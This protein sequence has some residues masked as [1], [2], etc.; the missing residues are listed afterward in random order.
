MNTNTQL[1]HVVIIGA[2]F[3][4]LKAARALAHAPVQVTLIDRNNYHLFQP[5]LYQVATAGITP[6][7]IAYPVRSIFR[8]QRNLQFRLA[9]VKAIDVANRQLLTSRGVVPY[10]SLIVAAGGE[11][12][13]FGLADVAR[14]STGMKTLEDATA[15]RNHL[16]R[17]FE[18]AAQEED[19][20]QR[21]AHLSFVIV[22]GGPTGVETAGALSE[23]VEMILAHD[24]PGV[25]REEISVILL[26]ANDRLL[27]A[28]PDALSRSAARSLDAKGVQLRF[29]AQVSG[30]DGRVARLRSGEELAAYTLIWAAGVRAV[31]LVSTLGGAIGSLGR[32]KVTPTLQLPG[33]PE[34]YV[35]GDAAALDGPDGSPLPMLAPVAM[36]Q[37]GT[38]AQNLLRGLKGLLPRA[39]SYRDP[40][41]LATIGRSQA[42]ARLWGINFYGFLAWTVWL[43]VHIT[44]LIGFR[45]R[46]LVLINWAWE[47]LF[48]DRVVRLILNEEPREELKE[49][50]AAEAV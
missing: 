21:R 40:G 6:E 22:G 16:L 46:L 5:L 33:H 47:Y 27:A 30:Y 41:T 11:T 38:A 1:H 28:M 42:V 50:R 12:H 17:Q 23:L 49:R 20:E 25:S 19:A 8:R 36:Q 2:G 39:F 26:E 32:V 37:G 45:N 9:E 48:Y 44:Q 29:G 24:A 15:I 10:D 13:T 3:G 7:E 34:I 31:P 4:G 35:I 18:L 43:V 14:C